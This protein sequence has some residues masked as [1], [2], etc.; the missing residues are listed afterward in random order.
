[1]SAPE[2]GLP[3][4]PLRARLLDLVLG[5][6]RKRRI[7]VQRTLI[8]F[9]IYA[10]LS[11]IQMYRISRGLADPW[12]GSVLIGV[13]LAASSIFYVATR[14]GWSERFA[15]PALTLPQML[16]GMPAAA[17]T[18]ASGGPGRGALLTLI[19]VILMFGAF[20]LTRRQFA[21]VSS[22]GLVCLGTAMY[23]MSRLHPHVFSPKEEIVHFLFTLTMLPAIAVLGGQFTDLRDRLRHQKAELSE[24]LARIQELATHDE[25]TGLYNRRHMQGMLEAEWRRCQRTAH[26]FSVGLVDLDHFKRLNDE[27]GHAAGDEALRLFAQEARCTLRD[28]DVVARWGGE[29]FLV[30]LPS[31]KAED[32]R[33]ALERLRAALAR[34]ARWQ[35]HPHLKFS[36]S[37]GVAEYLPGEDI[38]HTIERADRALYAAKQAGRDRIACAPGGAPAAGH[39]RTA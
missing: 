25:L 9:A 24:A 4:A 2:Q 14:T 27:Y 26:G 33:C 12:L 36:F 34:H 11:V 15:D 37:A 5:R 35:A 28:S 23:T 8:A 20:N 3:H 32:A 17:L 30:L 31:V 1:M 39:Q 22:L 18:Y 10:A 7:R 21:L 29:E 6:E 13:V 16:F 38:H 19:A